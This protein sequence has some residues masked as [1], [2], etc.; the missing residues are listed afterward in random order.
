MEV[1]N[2]NNDQLRH[3]FS[4]SA[5]SVLASEPMGS[6]LENLRSNLA[7]LKLLLTNK[8]QPPLLLV[9]AHL[10]L[11][12]ILPRRLLFPLAITYRTLE[13]CYSRQ[14]SWSNA[15]CNQLWWRIKRYR[16][17]SFS[18]QSYNASD[19]DIKI[20]T[21]HKTHRHTRYHLPFFH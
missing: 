5:L 10:L 16:L 12:A 18:K 3:E 20:Q 1:L 11:L 15:N 7:C 21:R 13:I 14:I 9:P 19:R 8:D 2:P 6:K 17:F 4:I